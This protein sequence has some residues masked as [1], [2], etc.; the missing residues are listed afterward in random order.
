MQLYMNVRVCSCC[1]QL[2]LASGVRAQIIFPKV[3]LNRSTLPL[4]IGWYGV[5][6]DFLTPATS[7]NSLISWLS[8]DAPWSEWIRSGKPY[9]QKYLSHNCLATCF[10]DWSLHGNEC[11]SL[12]KWSVTTST[13]TDLLLLSSAHQKSMHTISRGDVVLILSNGAL[14]SGSTDL[15]MTHLGQCLT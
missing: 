12:V 6:W 8:N 13:S 4:P 10:A 7:S 5:V 3:L 14:P 11:D 9:I 2:L 15:P 1:G